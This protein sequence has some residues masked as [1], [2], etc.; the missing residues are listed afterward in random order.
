MA[1][2]VYPQLFWQITAPLSAAYLMARICPASPA[3]DDPDSDLPRISH[4]MI[5][6]PS[7]LPEPPAM[8][9]TP[10]PLL[11]TA[12]IVPATCVPCISSAEKSSSPVSLMKL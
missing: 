3:P 2:A 11:F 12:A 6:T 10:T 5:F 4:D 9:Q 8:P 7:P 1:P